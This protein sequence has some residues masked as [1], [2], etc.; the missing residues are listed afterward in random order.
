MMTSGNQTA[1]AGTRHRASWNT[2]RSPAALLR[3]TPAEHGGSFAARL[4]FTVTWP[5]N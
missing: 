4:F 3:G 1:K 2:R 5:G